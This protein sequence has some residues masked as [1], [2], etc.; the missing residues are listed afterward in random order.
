MWG[1]LAVSIA[2]IGYLLWQVVRGPGQRS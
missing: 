2:M 1:A